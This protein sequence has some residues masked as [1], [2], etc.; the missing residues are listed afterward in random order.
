[1]AT[2]SLA[3]RGSPG[4]AQRMN[5]APDR[6]EESY[7][8]SGRLKG[9]KA[10]ITGGDSGKDMRPLSGGL[11]PAHISVR[12]WLE[13]LPVVRK[14]RFARSNGGCHPQVS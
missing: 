12:V 3:A 6:G 10:L 8:G 7:E 14:I 9:R 13:S 1:M 11:H 5:P 4:L 2:I